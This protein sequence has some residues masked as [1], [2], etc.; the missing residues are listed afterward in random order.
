MSSGA[1]ELDRAIQDLQRAFDFEPDNRDVRKLLRE[2][3]EQRVR[4]RSL[5]KQTFS[6]MFDRGQ[7]YDEDKASSP[8]SNQDDEQDE[9]QREAKFQR[10]L[11][12][13][14][15][16]AHA[17]ERKGQ[18][19]HAAE[20]RDRIAQATEARARRLK[21]VDFFHP[22]AEMIQNAKENG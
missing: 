15:R 17:F 18:S 20:I 13:A 10:E 12:D 3:K 7:V 8:E 14:N 16:I 22:S 11:E 4:Q 21:R 19:E 2:L 9:A 5:D 6:G 1:L